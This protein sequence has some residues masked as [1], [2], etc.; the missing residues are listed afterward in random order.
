MAGNLE[1]RG[2]SSDYAIRKYK[3]QNVTYISLA[4]YI[5]T[6]LLV[7]VASAVSGGLIWYELISESDTYFV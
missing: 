1:L 7:F 5:T 2:D 6:C 3:Q 4:L